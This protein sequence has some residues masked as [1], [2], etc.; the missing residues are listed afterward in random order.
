VLI[1]YVHSVGICLVNTLKG[2]DDM[3]KNQVR[4]LHLRIGFA[5]EKFANRA[6]LSVSVIQRV[7]E[8]NTSSMYVKLRILEALGLSECTEHLHRVFPGECPAPNSL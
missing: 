3:A 2:E 5:I 6:R 1:C 4:E 7:E 8:G